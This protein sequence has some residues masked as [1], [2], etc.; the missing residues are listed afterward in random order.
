MKLPTTKIFPNLQGDWT[1]SNIM[2][3]NTYKTGYEAAP[4]LLT[5]TN[6]FSNF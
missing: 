3:I 5:E 2:Y 4:Q 1:T 6:N